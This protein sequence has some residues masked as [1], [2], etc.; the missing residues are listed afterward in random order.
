[1]LVSIIVPNHGRDLTLLKEA[2]KKSSYPAELIVIDRGMERSAQ[3]NIGIKEA[4]LKYGKHNHCLF[5]LDSDQ[6][7]HQSLIEEC[8]A[9]IGL[10]YTALYIP[11]EI[12]ASSWFGRL[13]QFERQF[14]TATAVDVPRFVR[15]DSCPLFDEKMHGPEDSDWGNRIHGFIGTTS[16]PLYHYDDISISEYF[17]KKAYYSR[18]MKRFAERNPNDKV[19]S[20]K[21]RCWTVFTEKSKWKKIIRHPL[22]SLGIFVIIFIRG[23]IYARYKYCHRNT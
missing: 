6:V 10:G 16:H 21:Y 4:I 14:Y 19:L 3:R 2:V 20:F 5:I 23:L 15:A 18:S 9:M 22:S 7:P 17:K 8:V 13:R 1:M 12:V 11:E